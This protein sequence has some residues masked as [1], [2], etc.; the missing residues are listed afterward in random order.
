MTRMGKKR[1]WTEV[2]LC[3]AI[4]TST[5][6]RQVLVKLGLGHDAGGN[7]QQIQKYIKELG[8]DTSHFKGRGWS[9][10]MT[11]LFRPK[12]PLEKILIKGISYH[13]FKLKKRLFLA[14]LKPECCE[15]C[16]WAERTDE[17]HLPLELD[18]INGNHLDNRLNN[19]RVLCPNCH[20]LTPSYRG[21]VGRRKK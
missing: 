15:R 1:I 11:G 17:G 16:G 20:S 2:Q 10:G 14:K 13:S 19:L 4:K 8:L 3:G 18:H 12:V 9:K 5:S 21:R 7:Y 6:L